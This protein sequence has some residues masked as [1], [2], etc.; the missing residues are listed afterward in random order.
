MDADGG[1][2]RVAVPP[3]C[4][5]GRTPSKLVPGRPKHP[6]ETTRGTA[7]VSRG[8]LRR[9]RHRGAWIRYGVRNIRRW[10][11]RTDAH[12]VDAYT[13]APVAF[14][15]GTTPIRLIDL[16]TSTDTP[17]CGSALTAGRAC[18]GRV[19][20]DPHPAWDRSTH[21]SRSMPAGGS[22]SGF[23]CGSRDALLA[24]TAPT[25]TD[26]MPQPFAGSRWPVPT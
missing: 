10:G 14:G 24:L 17:P 20:V 11:T 8:W 25:A 5:P 13:T 18:P 15:D 2:I 26:A 6:D 21:A 16:V 23:R 12:L 22:P 9:H 7:A 19:A 1:N 4:E 3:T